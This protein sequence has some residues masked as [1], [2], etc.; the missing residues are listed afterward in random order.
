MRYQP[1]LRQE[2]RTPCNVG[3]NGKSR[4]YTAPERNSC[5]STS[6]ERKLGREKNHRKHRIEPLAQARGLR[7]VL[8]AGCLRRTV[9]RTVPPGTVPPES[10]ACA[11]GSI[12]E[13]RE[14]L[15][16]REPQGAL[17]QRTARSSI[18]EN[19]EEL[20]S[21]TARSFTQRTFQKTL[22]PPKSLLRDQVHYQRQV[23]ARIRI[24]PIKPG[25]RKRP[26]TQQAGIEHEGPGCAH[27][28]A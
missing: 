18:S 8:Q 1:T 14:G 16:F 13:N 4:N 11:R 3:R 25:D 28:T 22:N 26:V 20:Y 17:F 7:L 19:H 23:I 10:L 27:R 24:A 21:R 15:Y 5:A 6:P 9:R 12:S 2:S